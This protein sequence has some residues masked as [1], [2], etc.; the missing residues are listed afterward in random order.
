MKML[1]TTFRYVSKRG[2]G[3]SKTFYRLLR[4]R[5]G[6]ILPGRPPKIRVKRALEVKVT[7][8]WK[9]GDR[10]SLYKGR[11]LDP[12]LTKFLSQHADPNNPEVYFEEKAIYDHARTA[13]A[14]GVAIRLRMGREPAGAA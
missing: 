12:F 11:P 1:I 3:K 4:A 9:D 2:E 7:K 5:S 14:A 6:H 10:P 13:H 8:V